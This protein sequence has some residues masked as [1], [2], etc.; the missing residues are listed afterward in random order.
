METDTGG[1][2][3]RFPYLS[4]G[5][6]LEWDVGPFRLVHFEWDVCPFRLEWGVGPFRI[7]ASTHEHSE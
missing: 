6:R 3:V 2:T 1:P 7:V 5:L 4:E